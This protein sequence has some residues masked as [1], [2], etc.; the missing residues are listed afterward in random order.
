MKSGVVSQPV[1]QPHRS[2]PSV[3]T[4]SVRSSPALYIDTEA[5]TDRRH[6]IPSHHQKP[7]YNDP[8]RDR[9]THYIDRQAA[10]PTAAVLRPQPDKVPVLN[11]NIDNRHSVEVTEQ[12]LTAGKSR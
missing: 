6:P 2:S 10:F 4:N 7:F 12:Y 3:S 11:N 1:V 8:T 5:R 9:P